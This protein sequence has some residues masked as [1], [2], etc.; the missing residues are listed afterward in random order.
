MNK[1]HKAQL[2]DAYIAATPVED[3]NFHRHWRSVSVSENHE[4]TS[5]L[6]VLTSTQLEGLHYTPESPLKAIESFLKHNNGVTMMY[7]LTFFGIETGMAVRSIHQKQMMSF[8][9]YGDSI[10]FTA[11]R[12]Y[13]EETPNL[14][15]GI[16]PILVEGFADAE[17]LGQI[18]PFVLATMGG[19]IKLGLVPMIQRSFSQ[20][21]TMMDNDKPGR[22]AAGL[23]KKRL[24]QVNITTIPID[25]PA[26][27]ND[28]ADFYLADPAELRYR[29]QKVVPIC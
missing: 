25:Y 24:S 13:S 29:L 2:T 14:H 23:I 6:R 11:S 10:S 28:P 7:P 21:F 9:Y 3:V 20:V 1:V 22:K 15:V 27:H 8:S 26:E 12:F 19:P 17:A 18:Y 5:V 16:K 4:Y